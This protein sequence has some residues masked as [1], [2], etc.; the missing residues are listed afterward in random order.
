MVEHANNLVLLRILAVLYAIVAG[1]HMIRTNAVMLATV[2]VMTPTIVITLG[3]HASLNVS[4]LTVRTKKS[5]KQPIFGP[6][7]Q[8]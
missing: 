2:L 8:R 1:A 7:L 3:F 6:T 4:E 5:S